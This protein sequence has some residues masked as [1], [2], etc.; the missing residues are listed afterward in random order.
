M[1]KSKLIAKFKALKAESRARFEGLKTARTK[2]D[3]LE[4]RVSQ[5]E[6][7]VG[8]ALNKGVNF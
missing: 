7:F 2:I 8:T 1:K 6:V 5:L 3:E 4:K